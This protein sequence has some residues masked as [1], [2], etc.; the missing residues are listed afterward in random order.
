MSAES[1][2]E[3]VAESEQE[4][5]TKQNLRMPVQ[6]GEEPDD[7]SELVEQFTD[8]DIETFSDALDNLQS[9]EFP[10]ANFSEEQFEENRHYM[11]VIQERVRAAMPH[12]NQDVTGILREWAHDD[13]D[14]GLEQPSREDLLKDETGKQAMIA[15]STKGKDG[16]LLKWVL[17]QIRESVVRRDGEQGGG[18]G[19]LGRFRK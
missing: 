13:P 8:S 7:T 2:K 1:L 6:P 19:L 9:D 3:R 17:R 10:T 15:R 18:G 14:A 11:E 4:A 16:S 12:E 5:A